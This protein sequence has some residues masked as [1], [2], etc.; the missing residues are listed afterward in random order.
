[1]RKQEA[2]RI[3][4]GNCNDWIGLQLQLF[5]HDLVAKSY[6]E[7]KL[8]LTIDHDIMVSLS[9]TDILMFPLTTLLLPCLGR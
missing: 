9:K 1:M 3:R 7:L 6:H 2:V 4:L 5:H 8:N